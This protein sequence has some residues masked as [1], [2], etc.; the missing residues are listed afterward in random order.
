MK[1]A[2]RALSV[3]IAVMACFSLTVSAFAEPVAG[4]SD[5]GKSD[6]KVVV[7]GETTQLTAGETG[8]MVD[9]PADALPEGVEKIALEAK[10]ISK[11][12]PVYKEAVKVAKEKGFEN[13]TVLD[14]K[15]LDQNSSAISSLNGKIS[16]TIPVQ[17]GAN[18][19]LYFNDETN[20]VENL[21][22]TVKNGLITFETSHFSYYAMAKV[23]ETSSASST[24]SGGGSNIDTPTTGDNTSATVVIIAL[25]ALVA[26]GTVVITMIARKKKTN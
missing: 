14:L 8:V 10:V 5:Y 9:V 12:S 16:V 17:D 23:A 11:E 26:G 22:G 13:V 6:E 25:M 24:P 15:L 19:V 20:T 3:A 7:E 2:K 1:I 21:G 4:T 18:T